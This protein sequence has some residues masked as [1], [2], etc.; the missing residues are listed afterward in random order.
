MISYSAGVGRTGTY[1]TVEAMREQAK[2]EGV[3]DVYAYVSKMRNNR[4]KMV[5][6]FV[7]YTLK[8]FCNSLVKWNAFRNVK[9]IRYRN[10]PFISA[11]VITVTD[12][13]V[14]KE[15]QKQKTPLTQYTFLVSGTHYPQCLFL[16][17]IN[18][19]NVIKAIFRD[20]WSTQ[21]PFFFD[22]HR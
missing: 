9:L 20:F 14:K 4:M 7:S 3:V 5:Q 2:Q 15:K 21:A 22:T 12:C 16:T 17:N 1:I 6:T 11:G 8:P 10:D 19:S 18:M 13:P